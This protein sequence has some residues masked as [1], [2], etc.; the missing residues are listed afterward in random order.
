MN[1]ES[2]SIR[3]LRTDFRRVKRKIEQHGQI[4]ITDNGEP[5]FLIKALPRK[6]PKSATAPDYYAR[7]LKHQPKPLSGPQTNAFWEDERGDR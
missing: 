1:T 5:A 2:A 7:L 3:E 6:P 4:I